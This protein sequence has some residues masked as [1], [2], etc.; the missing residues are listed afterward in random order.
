MHESHSHPGGATRRSVLA[1][2]L[3][4]G[5]LAALGPAANAVA[6]TG[7]AAAT[8]AGPAAGAAPAADWFAGP[9]KAVRPKFRWWWPDGLVDPAEVAREIDR[10]GDRG[11]GAGEPAAAEQPST[12]PSTLETRHPG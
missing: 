1:A 9:A 2:G 3:S 11:V 12:R 10:M 7:S 6:A 5:V 8:E 4:T